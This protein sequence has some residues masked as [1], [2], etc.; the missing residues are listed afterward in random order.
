MS[1]SYG[2][3]RSSSTRKR[4][5]FSEAP[6]DISNRIPKT[7][8]ASRIASASATAK[9]QHQQEQLAKHPMLPHL[10]SSSS[11]S[12]NQSGS[13]GGKDDITMKKPQSNLM[14]STS[15]SRARIVEGSSGQKEQPPPM[16]SQRRSLSTSRQRPPVPSSTK[17]TSGASHSSSTSSDTR[18]RMYK[19]EAYEAKVRVA[20]QEQRIESLKAELDELRFFQEVEGGHGLESDG[21]D[22]QQQEAEEELIERLA[23]DLDH[24]ENDLK[25]ANEKNVRLQEELETASNFKKEMEKSK[26]DVEEGMTIMKDLSTAL[27][28]TRSEKEKI[29]SEKERV[30]REM[31]DLREEMNKMKQIHYEEIQQHQQKQQ[32]QQLNDDNAVDMKKYQEL[33]DANTELQNVLTVVQTQSEKKLQKMKETLIEANA[34]EEKMEEDHQSLVRNHECMRKECIEMEETLVAMSDK[35]DHQKI[36][37][38]KHLAAIKELEAKH[39]KEL[40]ELMTRHDDEVREKVNHTMKQGSSK[41]ERSQQVHEINMAEKEKEHEEAL[42]VLKDKHAAELR[43]KEDHLKSSEEMWRSRVSELERQRSDAEHAK[44]E[45]EQELTRSQSKNKAFDALQ[46]NYLSEI[47]SLKHTITEIQEAAT[48]DDFEKR[49][50]E[51]EEV[52]SSLRRE[53]S[54][55]KIEN[56]TLSNKISEAKANFECKLNRK[57]EEVQDFRSQFADAMKKNDE[58][59]VKNAALVKARQADA[60]LAAANK[61]LKQ[62]LLAAVES[63]ISRAKE[64]QILK[65]EI[66]NS[67]SKLAKVTQQKKELE[68]SVA[69]PPP[70]VD[71]GMSEEEKIRL[72]S[73]ISSLKSKAWEAEDT[74][75]GLE[76]EISLLR[77]KVSRSETLERELENSRAQVME[78]METVEAMESL[79]DE[80]E[81]SNAKLAV[82]TEKLKKLE[83][84]ASLVSSNDPAV[85]QKETNAFEFEISSLKLKAY[86]AEDKIA[87]LEQEISHLRSKASHAESLERDLNHSRKQARELTEAVQDMEM[88]LEAVS[89]HRFGKSTL[90]QITISSMPSNEDGSTEGRESLG[91]DREQEEKKKRQAI[92]NDILKE[93]FVHRMNIDD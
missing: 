26:K 80:V 21:N 69:T 39:K 41:L 83:H 70:V 79:Q 56:A 66:Q 34:R 9:Q 15:A 12:T 77:S 63:S 54:K 90:Q 74:V 6:R 31:E 27:Q 68:K 11:S 33:Q 64:I 78:L 89:R 71:P 57:E 4:A 22:E 1:S 24:L 92:E 60:V 46:A 49:E 43:K 59:S 51:L 28:S 36:E 20:A 91:D 23:A 86:E 7:S 53:N 16:K 38:E 19:A 45:V 17:S 62:D 84:C 93:Y 47:K 72:E 44:N 73:E 5:P 61:K 82:A 30:L 32:Y 50:K 88:A 52:A 37:A 42:A 3:T 13:R 65:K 10:S 87:D 48:K 8:S 85:S 18:A 29:R 55:L 75:S 67:N 14:R 81:N 25:M 35:F 2:N 58:L 40:E 76:H